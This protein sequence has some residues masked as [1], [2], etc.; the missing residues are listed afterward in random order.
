MKKWIA[1][2]PERARTIRIRATKKYAKNHPERILASVHRRRARVKAADGFYTEQ[3]VQRQLDSQFG[4]CCWCLKPMLEY[5]V[6]HLI[7]LDRNGS[8]WTINLLCACRSCNCSKKHLLPFY[9]W[10]PPFLRRDKP[11]SPLEWLVFWRVV[12][13]FVEVVAM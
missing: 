7:P 1:E 8:N 10:T 6:E 4:L 11:C 2:N 3:E 5:T 9:E 13:R 12:E